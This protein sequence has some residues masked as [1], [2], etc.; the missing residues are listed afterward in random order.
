MLYEAF[1]RG[2]KS[3]L[4]LSA[5]DVA[6]DEYIYY[7]FLRDVVCSQSKRITELHLFILG[8]TFQMFLSLPSDSFPELEAVRLA[9]SGSGIKRFPRY[10]PDSVSVFRGAVRLQ[11]IEIDA[12]P[13]NVNP[14]RFPMPVLA[15]GDAY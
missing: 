14:S 1:R 11:R 5:S 12:A 13:L 8:K 15:P 10:I 3:R 6:G 7:D 4:W 9:V 2:G